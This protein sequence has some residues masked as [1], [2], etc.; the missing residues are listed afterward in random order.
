MT[1]IGKPLFME[2]CKNIFIGN[3]VRIFP[4]LRIQT[5]KNGKIKIGDNVAIEQN[6]HEYVLSFRVLKSSFSLLIAVKM[7]NKI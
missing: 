3:R 1:Y 4:G 7:F 5:L 6:V 2:G